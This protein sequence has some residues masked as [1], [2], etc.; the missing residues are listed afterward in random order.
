[1]L[2]NGLIYFQVKGK[3]SRKLKTDE[4][5]WDWDDTQRQA[6]IALYQLLQLRI[7]K[8]WDPPVPDEQFIK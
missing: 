1:M 5:S 3:K 6:F 2:H 7:S 8:L 4:T